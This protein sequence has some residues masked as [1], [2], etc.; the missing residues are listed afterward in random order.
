MLL[1]LT[2]NGKRN[3]SHIPFLFSV[4]KIL[5]AEQL[6]AVDRYTIGHEPIASI[7]LME[8]AAAAFVKWL[9][10]SRQVPLSKKRIFK[11]PSPSGEGDSRSETDEARGVRGE[12]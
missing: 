12:A 1:C 2:V 11:I 9:L 8:R 6:R 3:P 10:N 5:S 4:M 7:D